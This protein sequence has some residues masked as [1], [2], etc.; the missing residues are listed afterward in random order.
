MMTLNILVHGAFYALLVL[1]SV[2]LISII[3]VIGLRLRRKREYSI[4][5]AIATWAGICTSVGSF[6]IAMVNFNFPIGVLP[7]S[8]PAFQAIRTFYEDIQNENCDGAWKLI[9]SARKAILAREYGFGRDQFCDAYVTT[10]IYHNLAIRREDDK[11]DLISSRLYRV[12][13]DVDDDL[14][15]N[16]IYDFALKDYADVMSTTKL[17]DDYSL[18]SI[19][20]NIRLYFDVPEDDVQIIDDV[21]GR[22]P[23]WSV[24]APE[25]VTEVV[26]LLKL[27]YKIALTRK[28]TA[29][30]TRTIERHFVHSITMEEDEQDK[31]H[32]KI[33]DGLAKPLL[34]APYLPRDKLL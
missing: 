22:M 29:P 25:M 6:A 34:V 7:E 27:K 3:V 12:A 5:R 15:R 21:I 2:S 8:D 31:D 4:P 32:W 23:F 30:P 19:I 24:S 1:S 16:N 14:P 20:E 26:R 13:Y 33:R 28:K 17:Q 11:G 10:Q 18:V 9:H